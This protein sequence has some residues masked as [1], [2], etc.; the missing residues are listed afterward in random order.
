MGSAVSIAA[1]PLA[2][3]ASPDHASEV[4]CDIVNDIVE[5]ALGEG[6]LFLGEDEPEEHLAPIELEAGAGLD[7]QEQAVVS[8]KQKALVG[9]SWR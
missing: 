7:V 2:E 3:R 9:A 5:L 6:L 8:R 1:A 4:P